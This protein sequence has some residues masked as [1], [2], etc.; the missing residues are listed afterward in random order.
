MQ[1]DRF[2]LVGRR[3]KDKNGETVMDLVS[4]KDT[5]IRAM[6]RKSQTQA[7]ISHDDVANGEP[8]RLRIECLCL[9]SQFI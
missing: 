8:Y 2:G 9:S 5:E 6:L 4:P 3:I 1:S 7:S